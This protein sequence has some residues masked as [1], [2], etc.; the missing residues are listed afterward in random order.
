MCHLSFFHLSP[1][2]SRTIFTRV[3][4]YFTRTA[5]TMIDN[6]DEL[7]SFKTNAKFRFQNFV[8]LINPE[9][10]ARLSSFLTGKIAI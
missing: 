3:R 8:Q 10:V 5:F 2:L 7:P 6:P 9:A 1:L 4:G